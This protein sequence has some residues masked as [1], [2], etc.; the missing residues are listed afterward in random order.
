MNRS[1]KT[2]S[3]QR[4]ERLV[5]S[6]EEVVSVIVTIVSEAT[7]V[8]AA[9]LPPLQTTLDGDALNTIFTCKTDD[10]SMILFEYAGCTV[11][12]YGDQTVVVTPAIR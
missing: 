9:E 7:N 1:Q 12:Y 2:D 5:T 6:D 10:E 3:S 4:I 8:S 11:R